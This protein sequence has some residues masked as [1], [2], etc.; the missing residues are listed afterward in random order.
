[1]EKYYTPSIEE[2]RVGFEYEVY[3]PEKELWSK[4]TFYLDA[5]HI[6][7]VKYVNIQTENTLKKVRVKYL[8]RE[9]IESLGWGNYE[10]PHEYNH[11]WNLRNYK[12]IAW[13]N[14]DIPTVRIIYE[15]PI[16]FQGEVKNKSELKILLK[17]LR[18]RTDEE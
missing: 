8:D 16:I 12:L 3:V 9:D 6:N 1:M 15:Y 18:I 11:T 10:P 13:F 7:L 5:S 17:Q 14:S 2:F 4:E